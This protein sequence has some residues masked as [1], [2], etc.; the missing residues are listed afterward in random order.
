MRAVREAA[1][2]SRNR[3]HQRTQL[4]DDVSRAG[5][6]LA[7]AQCLCWRWCFRSRCLSWALK[8]SKVFVCL[9]V[10]PADVDGSWGV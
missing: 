1:P 4:C 9:L 10:R 2:G 5:Q 8:S 3:S 7:V 6:T